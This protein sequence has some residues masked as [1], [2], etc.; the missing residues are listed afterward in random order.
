M[1]AGLLRALGLISNPTSNNST[2]VSS[3][4][5]PQMTLEEAL[6]GVS[7]EPR[8][9][10]AL[11]PDTFSKRFEPLDISSRP[12]WYD[13]RSY[14]GEKTPNSFTEVEVAA[15]NFPYPDEYFTRPESKPNRALELTPAERDLLG[16]LVYAEARG[17]SLE[18][19]AAVANSILNRYLSCKEGVNTPGTF[20]AKGCELA[21]I[22]YARNQYQPVREGKLNAPLNTTAREWVDRAIDL[23]LNPNEFRQ[24]LA[25][26]GKTPSEINRITAATGFRTPYAYGDSSQNVNTARLGGHI[27]NTAGNRKMVSFV[28]ES[29]GPE[30]P[31]KTWFRIGAVYPMAY[32]EPGY[33]PA[34]PY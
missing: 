7:S 11:P 27:F 6:R 19:A 18:G 10:A 21:D 4:K 29:A 28:P 15:L 5:P 25:Q 8:T 13:G 33:L 30:E 24:K 32:T 31:G 17:E 34:S 12:N 23:A 20:N 1:L 9:P 14:L 16:R 22:I 3:L 2:T 26:R